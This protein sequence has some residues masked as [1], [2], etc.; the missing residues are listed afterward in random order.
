MKLAEAESTMNKTVEATQRAFNSIRTGR[1]NASLLDKVQVDYYGSP[2]SLKSLA[3]ITTPDATT[4]LIQ[5]YDRTSLNIV[6]K[7]ISLSDV[8]LTPSNDGSVIRLNIPPLTSDRRKELVKLAAKYAE[9]GRVGIR[10]IRRD[11]LDSIRKQEKAG[12]VSEDE[13]RDQQDKLQKITSKYT[14]KI[15]ELLAE[16]EKDITTV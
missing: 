8:G 6:E 11:A 9:E 15:D 3:N 5:P 7:A 10:N 12:E 2:T 4:I 16:K 1:A 13:S 14:A